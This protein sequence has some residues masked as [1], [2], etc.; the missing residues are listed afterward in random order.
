MTKRSLT[1][2]ASIA[3]FSGAMFAG[4]A[5][6]GT[7]PQPYKKLS[8]SEVTFKKKS[9]YWVECRY[10]G[11]GTVCDYVYARV[12]G[13]PGTKAKLQRIKAN[14]STLKRKSGYWVECRYSGLGEICEYVYAKPKP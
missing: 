1:L 9:G 3:V 13:E 12:K 11:L 2:L 10:T 6:G 4:P 14:D 5:I 7:K 8:T